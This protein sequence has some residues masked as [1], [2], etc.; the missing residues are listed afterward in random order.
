MSRFCNGLYVNIKEQKN[1]MIFSHSFLYVCEK[2]IDIEIIVNYGTEEQKSYSFFALPDMQIF[3]AI[4]HSTY[5]LYSD[6]E[7][8][9]LV[10]TLDKYDGQKNLTLYAKISNQLE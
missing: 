6:H 9:Q 8:T 2:C 4:D 3:L 10:S 7:F 5:G 1:N